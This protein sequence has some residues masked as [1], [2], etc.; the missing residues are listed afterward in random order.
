MD[1]LDLSHRISDAKYSIEFYSHEIEIARLY[2]IDDSAVRGLLDAKKK[3][4]NELMLAEKSMPGC[5][6]S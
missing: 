3:E 5:S 6:Q 1:K 4:L 2:A